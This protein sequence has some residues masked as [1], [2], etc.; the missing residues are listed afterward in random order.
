MLTSALIQC[1]FDYASVI[2]YSGLAQTVKNKLQ[3]VQNTV[4]GFILDLPARSHLGYDEFSKAN[5][6]PV[7]KRVDQLK[8]THLFNIIHGTVPAYL[9]VAVSLK[10]KARHQTRSS[11]TFSC[12]T[13]RVNS[14]WFKNIFLHN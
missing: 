4:I 13:P 10:E 12:Q 5:M 7:G 2:W 3:V 11:T 1:H 8:M 6:F 14:F 9:S